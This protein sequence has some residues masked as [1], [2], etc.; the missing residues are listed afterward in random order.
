MT[1]LRIGGKSLKNLDAGQYLTSMDE[2]GGT[3]L[4]KTVQ[5]IEARGGG[6][7]QESGAPRKEAA[8][9]AVDGGGAKKG[10]DNDKAS[11][12]IARSALV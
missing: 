7:T 6:G 9:R 11:G 2:I 8:E 4:L 5:G 10:S 3:A 1:N 12:H